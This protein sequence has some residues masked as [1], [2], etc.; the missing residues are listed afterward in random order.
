MFAS[1]VQSGDWSGA[2]SV[3]EPSERADC[4]STLIKVGSEKVMFKHWS[5]TVSNVGSST[6]EAKL[7]I[8]VCKDGQCECSSTT[9]GELVGQAERQL[10]RVE[11]NWRVRAILGSGNS[12]SGNSGNSGSSR[13]NFLVPATLHRTATSVHVA[14]RKRGVSF[15]TMPEPE[16]FDWDEW[17]NGRVYHLTNDELVGALL[18]EVSALRKR[19]KA[20]EDRQLQDSKIISPP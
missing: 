16:V 6:A 18:S 10:V 11:L 3:A 19:V 14:R 8:T 2:C 4:K 1:A 9:A 7:R 15:S 17:E 12:G 5:Y 20:L 13:L